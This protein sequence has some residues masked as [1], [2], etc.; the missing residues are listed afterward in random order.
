MLLEIYITDA[1]GQKKLY[2]AS[3]FEANRKTKGRVF[4]KK[5]HGSTFNVM[6]EPVGKKP[7]T[8]L[9]TTTQKAL[10][11]AAKAAYDRQLAFDP[12]TDA[13]DELET[14]E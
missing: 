14:Y 11:E 5:A 10:T 2:S 7:Y 3:E 6:V 12:L 8:L 1:T 13:L 4:L 9:S